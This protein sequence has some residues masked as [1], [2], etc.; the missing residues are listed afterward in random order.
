[1]YSSE[2]R[3]PSCRGYVLDDSNHMAFWK[4]RNDGDGKKTSGC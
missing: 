3:K 1:M 2:W 4:R